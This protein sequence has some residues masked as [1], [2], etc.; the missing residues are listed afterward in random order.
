MKKRLYIITTVL[1]SMAA[2]SLSSCLKDSRYVSFSQGGTV[3]NFPLGGL[4]H[5]GAD[6]V[7]DAGDTIVKQFS[8]DVASPT[9]PTSAT[10]VTIAVDNSIITSYNASQTAVNYN[11]MPDGSYVLSATKVTIPAGQRVGIVTVTFYKH[12]LDPTQ[13]YMLPIKIVSGPSGSIVSGNF[14]IHYYHFIGNDFAGPYLQDFIRTPPGGNFTAQPVTILPVTPTQFEVGSGYAGLGIRYEVTFTK[15]G[16]GPTAT[17]TNWAIVM[18]P[19]DITNVLN[20]AGIAMTQ[21]AVIVG[22]DP[23]HAYTYTEAT[24][25]LFNFLWKAHSSADRINN[26]KFYK[27]P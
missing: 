10:D 24:H 6:A 20:A 18:N 9:I 26:D 22:Y 17:Y 3:I 5:F 12:L 25:G 23:A 8:V 19:D 15:N 27:V 11:T 2:L 16:T 7:T 13:S 1:A 21:N 4:S 14:G